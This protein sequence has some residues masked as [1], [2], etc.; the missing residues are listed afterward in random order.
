MILN[1]IWIALFAIG[2]ILG[3]IKLCL[4]DATVFPAMMDSTF[5]TATQGFE[6]ALGL[7][8]VLTLW[9]GIM[10]V[11]EVGGAVGFL[12]RLLSPV[13]TKLFPEIPKGHPVFGSMF[14]NISANMLGLDNAAT[15]TGLKAMI[16][17]QELNKDKE[18]ASNSMIMFLT[19]V[20][21]VQQILQIFLSLCC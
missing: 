7:T 18:A 20:L 9:M 5:E 2:F 6:M 16:G 3:V 10:R 11:G 17:L 21:Q 14:M 1:Y 13:L 4:G 19:C 15:P 12:S 8:G